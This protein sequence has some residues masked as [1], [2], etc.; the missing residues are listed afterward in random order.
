MS[1]R[2]TCLWPRTTA[3][4]LSRTFA[5]DWFEP[6]VRVVAGGQNLEE[7]PLFGDYIPTRTLT[8]ALN[9]VV[10]GVAGYIAVH[11]GDDELSGCYRRMS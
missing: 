2:A 1:C 4:P 9:Q 11:S 10:S 5:H 6:H 3:K 7:L 8:L